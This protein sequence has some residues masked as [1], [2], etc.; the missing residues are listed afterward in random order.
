MSVNCRVPGVTYMFSVAGDDARHR[1]DVARG[2][3]RAAAHSLTPRDRRTARYRDPRR[4][5]PRPLIASVYS[6]LL[7][8]TELT[9]AMLRLPNVAVGLDSYHC[10]TVRPNDEWTVQCND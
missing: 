9:H 10:R 4:V 8:S 6:T 1:V 5:Q 7:T 2:L 3:P